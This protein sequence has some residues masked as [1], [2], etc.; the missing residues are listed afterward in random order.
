MDRAQL[1]IE[2]GYSTLYLLSEMDEFD[3]MRTMTSAG[4]GGHDM[5]GVN[6]QRPL[7]RVPPLLL[8]LTYYNGGIPAVATTM[9][10][11]WGLRPQ[12]P[13]GTPDKYLVDC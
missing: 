2:L 9:A 13:R 4:H 1:I 8:G 11:V 5:D 12:L 3:E 6:G 10:A 7:S